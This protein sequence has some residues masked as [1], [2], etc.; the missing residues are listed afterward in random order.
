MVHLQDV[1]SNVHHAKRCQAMRQRSGDMH[2]LD[3]AGQLR[4]KCRI[5]GVSVIC[6]MYNIHEYIYYTYIRM[7]SPLHT[8]RLELLL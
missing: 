6:N 7:S 5:Q 1:V 8:S 2:I 4:D 3:S